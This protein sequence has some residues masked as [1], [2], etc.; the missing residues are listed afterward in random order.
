MKTIRKHNMLATAATIASMA[1]AA[2]NAA[3]LG[4][5]WIRGGEF[6]MGSDDES[7]RLNERPPHRVKV[8]GFWMDETLVTNEQFSKFVEATGYVTTAERKPTWDELRKELPPGTPKPDDS[9]LVAGSIVFTPSEGPVDLREM[10]NFWRWV[11]GASWRHPEGPGS[12]LK[13][14]ENHP[15]VQ[16]SWDDAVAFCQWAGKRLPTE[17]QWEYAARGGLEKKRFAWGDEFRPCCKFMANT[18]TGKFSYD[19]TKDKPN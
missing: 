3:P 17:A 1:I 18:W 4:M 7:S 19:N 13:G 16:V 2:A 11:P 9:V 8:D 14:R 5:G 10:G 15:V 12:D 6:T